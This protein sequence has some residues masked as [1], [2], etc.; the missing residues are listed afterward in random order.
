MKRSY[1]FYDASTSSAVAKRRKTG[2]SGKSAKYRS[3]WRPG[4]FAGRATI[5][6]GFASPFP[7]QR[8]AKL[9]YCMTTTLD[10]TS[11]TRVLQQFRANSL[12]DPDFTSGG[13]QPY[14]FDTLDS[15]YNHYEVLSSVLTVTAVPSSLNSVNAYMTVG[16]LVSDDSTVTT[17]VDTI[18]EQANGKFVLLGGDG[19]PVTVVQKYNRNVMFPR[20]SD[21]STGSIMSTNPS[22]EAYFTVYAAPIAGI[23]PGAVYLMC[24]IDFVA[25]FWELKDL[26]QS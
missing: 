12:F 26:G 10:A 6:R 19:S 23:E 2:K 3:S 13:H 14:G 4:S 18:R 5:P 9:R 7:M 21:Y 8:I 16:V 1:S 17:S 20:S 22:D 25:R 15:I 11:A 24:T